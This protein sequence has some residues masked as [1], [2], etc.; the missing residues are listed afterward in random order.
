MPLPCGLSSGRL[1]PCRSHDVP[2]VG[3]H[4][5]ADA[6]TSACSSTQTHTHAQKRRRTHEA[7]TVIRPCQVKVTRWDPILG[8]RVAIGEQ[9]GGGRPWGDGRSGP[10]SPRAS[11]SVRTGAPG[12]SVREH[13]APPRTPP[14]GFRHVGMNERTQRHLGQRTSACEDAS[15]FLSSSSSRH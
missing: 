14:T 10:S 4:A 3:L 9:A 11:P 6:A 13:R 1:A 8:Q 2:W 5:P 15:G 12:V 7:V